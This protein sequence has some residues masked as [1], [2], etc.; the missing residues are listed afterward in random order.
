M[1]SHKLQNIFFASFIGF[2]LLLSS[3]TPGSCFEETNAFVKASPYL[4]STGKATPPDSLTLYGI[5]MDTSRIYNRASGVKLILMPL[6]DN[7]GSCTLVMKMNAI[8]DT[9]SFEYTS[10]PHL[11]SKECGYTYYHNVGRI[12]YT[13]HIIDTI[14]IRKSTVTTLNEENIRIYY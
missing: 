12:L 10:Y 9:V 3:C 6:N 2:I 8:Y 14:M 1:M 7:A 4:N 13:K 5:N 11:L